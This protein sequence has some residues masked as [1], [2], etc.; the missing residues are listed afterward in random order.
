MQIL[1]IIPF[2]KTFKK[3]TLTY[4]SSKDVP[5]GSIVTIT[6]RNKDVKGL[7]VSGKD[8]NKEKQD[9][10]SK[11]FS[12]K[13]IKSISKNSILNPSIIKSAN[14]LSDYF[15]TSPGAIITTIVPKFVLDNLDKIK[16]VKSEKLEEKT[17]DR[18][19]PKFV[20]QE[21]ESERYSSYKRLIREEFA[22]KKSVLFICP[23]KQDVQYAYQK[24]SKGINENTYTF[25]SGITKTKLL[26]KW[27]EAILNEKPVLIITT[28]TYMSLPREDVGSIVVERESSRSY[29]SIKAP[30]IDYRLFAEIYA[31][32][33]G[34]RFFLGDLVL[35]LETL[36]RLNDQEFHEF[37]PAKYR[38]LTTAKTKL[39]DMSEEKSSNGEE[40]VI[41]SDQM[42]EMIKNSN[43]ENENT[44]LFTSRR[45]L[46]PTIVCMDCGTIV[47]CKNCD[48]PMVLHGKDPTEKH[49]FFLCHRCNEKRPAGELCKKCEGWRLKTLGTG[50]QLIERELKKLFPDLKIFVL[51]SDHAKTSK[52]AESVIE[53]FNSNPGS[54][55][56]GTEMALLYLRDEI[57]NVGIVSIDSMFSNPDFNIKE[58]ILNT[59]LNAKQKA[60]KNFIVQTRKM[61]EDIFRYI[62]SGNLAEFVR[63]ELGDRKKYDYPPYSLLIKIIIK[64]T[65]AGVEKEI[66][67]LREFLEKYDLIEYPIIRESTKTRITKGILIKFD[68]KNWP[69]KDL[70]EK[71]R[72][73]PVYY[74]IV[75]NTENIF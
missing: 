55:L 67:N 16:K 27:N 58:R 68:R 69:K 42:I 28:P 7:V 19:S 70:V 26:K 73:L 36:V 24:M 10:K 50:S 71:L 13:K 51:D 46:S 4:F 44:F 29:K 18:L 39:I 5:V 37:T 8:A 60:T 65:P 12:L 59:V 45:G 3:D 9:L 34:I 75:V 15:A 20:V 32:N 41:L 22:K 2:Y 35:R 74:K 43:E 38:T 62:L 25:H 49:N 47:A 53:K 48:A 6:I 31:K 33:K 11:D 72:L 17:T 56:I 40:F 54:V 14:E 30:Y 64:G 63:F 23:T 57:D 61:D 66:K 52:Q 21:S 1:E